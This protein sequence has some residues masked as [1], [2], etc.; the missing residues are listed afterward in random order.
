M[1]VKLIKYEFRSSIKLMALIWAAIIVSSVLFSLCG[2]AFQ[3][4]V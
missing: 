3:R 4:A 1:T 2:N